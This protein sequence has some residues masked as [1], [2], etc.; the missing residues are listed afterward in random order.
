MKLKTSASSNSLIAKR[1]YLTIHKDKESIEKTRRYLGQSWKY[2]YYPKSILWSMKIGRS[3][4]FLLHCMVFDNAEILLDET[5]MRLFLGVIVSLVINVW[6][7]ET[8]D[9]HACGSNT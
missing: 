4:M 1:L 9:Q 5:K 6:V 3:M 7:H 2:F 8:W